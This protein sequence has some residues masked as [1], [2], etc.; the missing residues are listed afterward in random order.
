MKFRSLFFSALC[1]L[2]AGGLFTSCSDGDDDDKK[3]DKGTKVELPGKRVFTLCEG[4]YQKNNVLLTFYAPNHE[5]ETINDIFFKQNDAKLG[6]TGQHAI[7][8]NNNIYISMY[9]SRYVCRLNSAGV[10]QKRYAFTEEQGQPR[11]LLVE[12]GKLY[13]TLSSGNVARLDATSLTLEKMV[14]VGNNPEHLIEEDGKLYVVNSGFGYDNRLSI[15]DLNTFDQA[16]NVEIFQNPQDIVEANDQIF[17]LGYGGAYPDYTNPV[18]IYD[19][20]TKKYEEIGKGTYMCENDDV[21][22]VIYSET[23]YDNDTSS[24]TLYSYDAR[25]NKKSE[26]A[27]IQMPAELQNNII[28]GFS[29]DPENGDFYIGAGGY[30]NNGDVYRFKKDGTFIEKFGTGV[31]PKYSVFIY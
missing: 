9:G 1:M 19:R 13:V 22:Y 15:I 12:D 4:S 25:T 26:K 5:V 23:N 27:F 10:E 24:H 16:E 3:D 28:T 18:V 6:D 31:A 17:I 30:T 21:V 8:Y 2:M 29:I 14:K 20:A 11:Y 7:A